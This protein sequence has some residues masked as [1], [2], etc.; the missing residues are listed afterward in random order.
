MTFQQIWMSLVKKDRRLADPITKV[1]FSAG[2]LKKLLCAV[3]AKGIHW[4]E[5]HGPSIPPEDFDFPEI[6]DMPKMPDMPDFIKDL[7]NRKAK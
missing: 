7:F 1:E 4:G 3:Y 5:T 6:P 2:N